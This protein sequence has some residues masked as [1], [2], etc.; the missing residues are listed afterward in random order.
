MNVGAVTRVTTVPMHWHLKFFVAAVTEA[1]HPIR[2]HG[3]VPSPHSK[4]GYEG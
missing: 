1:T 4:S 2:N 3:N